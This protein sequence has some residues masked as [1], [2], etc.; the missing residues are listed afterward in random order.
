MD[1]SIHLAHNHQEPPKLLKSF[2]T[3]A[4]NSRASQNR[5]P[6]SCAAKGD[7]AIQNLGHTAVHFRFL[8]QGQQ[9]VLVFHLTY[10]SKKISF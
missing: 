10:G 9:L 3:S 4:C 1:A 6:L 2:S 7:L 8:Q 5:L